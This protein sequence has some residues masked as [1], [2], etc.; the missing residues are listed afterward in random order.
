MNIL[1]HIGDLFGNN[2]LIE[3]N[4]YAQINNHPRR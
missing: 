1:D 4:T 3:R 2:I